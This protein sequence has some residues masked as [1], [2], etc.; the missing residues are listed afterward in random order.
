MPHQHVTIA[1][2]SASV[3]DRAHAKEQTMRDLIA[4]WR[5][6]TRTDR[7]VG[8]ATLTGAT[9]VAALPYLLAA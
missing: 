5:R 1:T 8:L 6:W 2:S 7:I 3:R 4:D 9:L